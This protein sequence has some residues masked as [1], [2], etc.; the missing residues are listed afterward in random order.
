MTDGV[1]SSG[2]PAGD[3]APPAEAGGDWRSLLPTELAE[4]PYI[5]EAASAQD[6]A[7]QIANAAQYQ[8]TS[9]RIPSGDA[10]AEQ[11]AEFNGKLKDKV[12]GLLSMPEDVGSLE[13]QQ[14]ILR[15]LGA[16]ADVNAYPD[17]EGLDESTLAGLK[18]RAH[19]RQ[20]TRAQ[21]EA[22]VADYTRVAEEN[23]AAQQQQ[24]DE[25]MAAIKG[26][27]GEAFGDRVASIKRVSEQLGF[28]AEVGEALVSG[29]L[30]PEYAKAFHAVVAAIG[31]G[32][33][34]NGHAQGQH[35]SSAMTP[36]EAHHKLGDLMGQM[37][38]AKP[39]EMRAIQRRMIEVRYAANPELHNDVPLSEALEL[40]R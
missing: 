23:T 39:H 35:Q 3:G 15:R 29:D 22:E 33:G 25:H 1:T 19:S 8:G 36:S 40:L 38:A 26:E 11:W 13:S 27:W 34:S 18:A 12:P 30:A 14:E 21:Y 9:I 32:E 7:A 5:K 2:P 28:P 6:A 17:V 31:N 37:D 20:W 10:S 16:G 4:S 24:R